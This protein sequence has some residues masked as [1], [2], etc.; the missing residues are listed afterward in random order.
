MP[1]SEPTI[2]LNSSRFGELIVPESRV[3]SCPEGIIGFAGFDRYVLLDPSG[4]ESVFLWLQSVD[5]PELAFII[6]DPT[7]FYPGYE[8]QT[9]EPD[10]E[11]LKLAGKPDPALFVIVTIPANDP[12]KIN[13]NLVAPLL[14]H[15]SDNTLHQLVL[16]KSDWPLRGYLLPETEQEP[17]TE[18]D[19][20]GEVQ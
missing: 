11:R 5:S 7:I 17:E 2:N 4:G 6:T 15:D 13:A 19:E 9:D 12:D 10:L 3:I 8:I 20:P 16:E 1:E 18:C 14:Y